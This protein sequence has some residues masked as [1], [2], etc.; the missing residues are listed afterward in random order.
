MIIFILSIYSTVFSG[1]YLVLAARG[2]RYGKYVSNRKDGLLT[3][4]NANLLTAFFAKTIEIS[5]AT[6]FVAFLGQVLWRRAFLKS[7]GRGVTLAEMDMR[8]W[9]MQPG[10]MLTRFGAMRSTVISFLGILTF[11]AALMALLYTTASE[12]LVQPQLRSGNWEPR[13]MQGVV[14]ASW[15]NSVYLSNICSSPMK[16]G[17]TV[18]GGTTC[19][20]IEYAAQAYH[21]YQRYLSD[22]DVPVI[23]GNGSTDLRTRP[24][25][26]ALVTENTTVSAP[27]IEIQNGGNLH[28]GRVVNNVSM[29]MPHLGVTSAAR[30]SRNGIMQPEVT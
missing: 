9:V 24:Q 29:A 14:K 25:G 15:G 11:A 23:Y 1:I 26:F 22:W 7:K 18:Y 2:P 10:T 6:V 28:N 8:S 12:A 27:W 19:L 5:F 30:D 20:Q 13:S 16:S 21:N 4:A 17:D 3:S